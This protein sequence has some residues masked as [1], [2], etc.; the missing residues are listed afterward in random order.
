MLPECPRSDVGERIEL[1]VLG[2]G[3]LKAVD[4]AALQQADGLGA[5]ADVA[6]GPVP[7]QAPALPDAPVV[8]DAAGDR[9]LGQE[10][11]RF[12]EAAGWS[13]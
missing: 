5:A 11:H 7:V 8:V 6:A 12:D 4:V 10:R 9:G 2:V 3:P 1:D 13:S